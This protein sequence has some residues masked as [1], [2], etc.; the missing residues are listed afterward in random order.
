MHPL[1]KMEFL[2][3]FVPCSTAAPY[4]NA[5]STCVVLRIETTAIRY[6]EGRHVYDCS[7]V[8]VGARRGLQTPLSVFHPSQAQV[9]SQSFPGPGEV[10]QLTVHAC[11]CLGT[12]LILQGTSITLGHG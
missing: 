5:V 10:F 9:D 4:H 3:Y 12:C 8:V 1:P 6:L 7:Y 11:A 2:Y